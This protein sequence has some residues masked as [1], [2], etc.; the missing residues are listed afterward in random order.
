MSEFLNMNKVQVKILSRMI[1]IVLD[2][3]HLKLASSQI[4]LQLS[5][6]YQNDQKSH[7]YNFMS[8]LIFDLEL[9]RHKPLFG[10]R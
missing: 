5:N 6:L 8:I 9:E 10:L 2:D 4:E 3:F 7:L 1:L